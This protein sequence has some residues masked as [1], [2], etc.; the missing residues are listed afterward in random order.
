MLTI[1]LRT[2]RTLKRAP[3]FVAVATLSLAVGIGLST[4][5]FAMMDSMLHPKIPLADVD[6]LFTEHLRLG[7][8]KNP[9]SVLEQ[10][11]ALEALPGIERVAVVASSVQ[12]QGTS[13][14]GYAWIA[15]TTPT[16]FETVGVKPTLGRMLSAD[17]IRTKSAVVM[18]AS[19]WH[20]LFPTQTSLDGVT[21]RID[22]REYPVVGVM[23]MGLER[24]ISGDVYLPV[25]SP[26]DLQDLRY[27][28]V[29]AKLRAGTDSMSIRPQLAVAA[30]AFTRRYV[31]P[32]AAPYELQLKSIRPTPPNLRDN[33]LAL[34]MVG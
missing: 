7:D 32:P 2:V 12:A 33:E 5:T 26:A 31:R 22:D 13:S 3:G 8:Q 6:R 30:A 21:F 11:R 23:P 34:L 18:S 29:I 17:E 28:M 9:P 24:I 27:S 1:L 20:R 25:S 10:V 19:G 14:E 16:F 15:R 4:A